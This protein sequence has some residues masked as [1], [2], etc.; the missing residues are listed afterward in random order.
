MSDAQELLKNSKNIAIVGVSGNKERASY[1]VAKWMI[2]NT[3]YSIFLVNPI[4]EELFGEKVYKS[5]SQIEHPLD[6]VDIFRKPELCLPVVQEAIALSVKSI[7][8]QL[9]IASKE[10]KKIAEE[11]GLGY[12]ED[13]CIKVEVERLC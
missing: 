3:D 1:Q 6:I 5:I 11:A 10:C 2:E 7:W 4:L 9:G 13:K 12:V 8:L